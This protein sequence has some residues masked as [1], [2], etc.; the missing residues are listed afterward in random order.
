MPVRTMGTREKTSRVS[1]LRV[2]AFAKWE[3]D[4]VEKATFFRFRSL[5][6]LLPNSFR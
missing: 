1:Q 6:E 3:I 4:F 5:L 2:A